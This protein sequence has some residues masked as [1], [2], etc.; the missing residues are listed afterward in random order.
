MN[1]MIYVCCKA[2]S[3]HKELLAYKTKHFDG[4]TDTENTHS[5]CL[6]N[7][8][9]NFCRNPPLPE[10]AEAAPWDCNEGLYGSASGSMG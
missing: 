5:T 1:Y 3:G 9:F 8:P 10:D 4:H 7:F 6:L 2:P